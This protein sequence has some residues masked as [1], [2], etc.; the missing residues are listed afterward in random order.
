MSNPARILI[1]DD[2]LAVNQLLSKMLSKVGYE[3]SSAISGS[4]ALEMLQDMHFELLLLD[5]ELG[6]MHGITLLK[7]FRSLQLDLTV[8]V[9]TAH[10]SLHTALEALRYGAADYL[11]KPIGM[12]ELRQRVEQHM[13][14]AQ[15]TVQR[16]LRIQELYTQ[17]AQLIKEAAPQQ[18]RET[19][20]YQSIQHLRV[21]D[22]L[23]IDLQQHHVSLAGQLLDLTQSEFRLLLALTE[24]PNMVVSYATLSAAI[25]YS[26][27]DELQSSKIIRPHISRLRQKLEPDPAKPSY[28]QLVRGLGYRWNNAPQTTV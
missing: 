16:Q 5:L 24:Q 6:D 28:I 21:L 23:V 18:I 1:I 11:Q 8:I 26:G 15:N 2:D 13:R 17:V 3:V 7:Q 20:L 9:V 25:S 10:G 22:Q 19:P 4:Q 12:E 14:H 27:L